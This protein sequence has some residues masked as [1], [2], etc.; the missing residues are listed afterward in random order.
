MRINQAINDWLDQVRE[1]NNLTLDQIATESKRYGTSWTT[2]FVSKINNSNT[3]SEVPNLIILVQTVNSLTGQKLTLADVFPGD[4]E[5]ELNDEGGHVDRAD[6]RK[7]LTGN[8][9]EIDP[10]LTA[11]DIFSFI[12]RLTEKLYEG[13]PE[14]MR[15]VSIYIVEIGQKVD[16]TTDGRKPSL[17]EQRAAKKIGIIPQALMVLCQLVFH[18]SLDEESA[19]RAGKNASP[20]KKGRETRKIIEYLDLYID[21]LV[22]NGPARLLSDASKY[23]ISDAQN[24]S[25][26]QLSGEE[27]RRLINEKDSAQ[28]NTGK[29][30]DSTFNDSSVEFR[31]DRTMEQLKK[32]PQVLAAYHDS[33]KEREMDP[34][35]DDDD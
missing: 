15:K 18:R 30:S 10:A 31:A 6:L 4:G 2:G 9:V 14:T 16:V 21:N 20:Q 26:I 11:D 13:I 5:I 33:N 7:I 28:E 17:A 23:D 27:L 12:D 19:Y 35:A 34:F 25:S 22:N 8:E 24:G 3:I 1:A 32:N 29:K